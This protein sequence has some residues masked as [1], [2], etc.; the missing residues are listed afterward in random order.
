VIAHGPAAN[1]TTRE[2]LEKIRVLLALPAPLPLL[3]KERHVLHPCEQRRVNDFR[4]V[5]RNDF[6]PLV[7]LFGLEF[8]D[9]FA[10]NSPITQ[11][12][13]NITFMPHG[14][15]SIPSRDALFHEGAGDDATAVATHVHVEDAAHELCAFFEHVDF[16]IANFK[17]ARHLARH[18][19]AIFR[20]LAFRFPIRAR[21]EGL[22]LGF[23]V[24][25]HHVRQNGE[26]GSVGRKVKDHVLSRKADSD[27]VL[28]DVQ[29]QH[30]R[31]IHPITGQPVEG[32]GD[33]HRTRRD[34]TALNALEEVAEFACQCVVAAKCRDAD[35]L[36]RFRQVQAVGF[37]EPHG[38]VVLPPFTVAPS[39]RLR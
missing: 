35:V 3:A 28:R 1:S 36:K 8:G 24:G 37:D 4:V 2:F 15:T 10:D 25:P 5:P 20:L 6:L 14:F 38:G 11:E 21:S 29:K 32:L 23:T 26:E 19:D 18:D 34:F 30:Q 12:F 9:V 22:V 13:V 27:P 31:L 7:A 16:A 17:P 33:E 39:L